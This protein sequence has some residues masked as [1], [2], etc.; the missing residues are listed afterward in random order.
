MKIK[1]IL[2][3]EKEAKR[4][5]VKI[6][7]LKSSELNGYRVK[8]NDKPYSTKETYQSKETGDLKRSSM[9]LTRSLSKLRNDVW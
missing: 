4:F 6:K 1:N 7:E 2:E 3:A 9:D 5:I 8:N